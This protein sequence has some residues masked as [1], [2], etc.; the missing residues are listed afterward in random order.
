MNDDVA[1]SYEVDWDEVQAQVVECAHCGGELVFAEAHVHHI[2][3]DKSDNRT[4][5]LATM[6]PKCHRE[7]H[8]SKRR[9]KS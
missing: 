5:N 8:A 9:T 2:N 1:P 3:G 4:S 7:V 6:H